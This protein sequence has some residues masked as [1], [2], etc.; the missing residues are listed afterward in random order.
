MKAKPLQNRVLVEPVKPEEKTAGGII[1]P[2]T[3]TEKANTGKVIRS[4][5][6]SVKEGDVVI[7]TKYS[8][9][10]VN[11]EGKD[12]LLMEEDDLLAIIE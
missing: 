4:A 6:E 1:I 9:T 5:L 7:F 2:T 10:E 8:G 3:G 11:L 12:Y